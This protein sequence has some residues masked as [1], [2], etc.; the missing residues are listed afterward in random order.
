MFRFLIFILAVAWL[1]ITHSQEPSYVYLAERVRHISLSKYQPNYYY[2][3]I[4]IKVIMRFANTLKLYDAYLFFYN[5][6]RNYCRSQQFVLAILGNILLLFSKTKGKRQILTSEAKSSRWGYTIH[7]V[8]SIFARIIHYECQR[9]SYLY[10]EALRT[11]LVPPYIYF[12]F[13]VTLL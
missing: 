10:L 4:S 8:W 1:R 2:F 11:H 13:V 5:G 3:F 7:I 9:Y 12:I 6:R